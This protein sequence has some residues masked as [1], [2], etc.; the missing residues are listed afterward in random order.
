MDFL[1]VALPNVMFIVGVIAIGLGLG[2]ELKLIE[3]KSELSKGG[4]I[5]AFSVG[6][7]L[8][9][10]SIFLYTRSSPEAAPAATPT[11]QAVSAQPSPDT[12]ATPA[13]PIVISTPSPLPPTT[14]PEAA[15]PT[16]PPV[17]PTVV[18]VTPALPADPLVDLQTLL[19]AGLADGR[20]SKK[21]GEDML[22]KL[23]EAQEALVKGDQKRA[24]DRLRDLQES[25]GKD[26]KIDPQLAQAVMDSVQQIAAQYNLDV[27][28]SKP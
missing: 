12:V 9:A 19:E 3:I 24:Q 13:A 4:R 5:G 20:V 2:I 16:V 28:S 18:V 25:V 23:R 17:E 10:I 8:I 11:G 14:P 1:G 6:V 7:V 21:T 22:K 15:T 26:K 27:P